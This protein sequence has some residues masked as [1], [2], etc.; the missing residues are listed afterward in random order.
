MKQR[1]NLLMLEA[2]KARRQA[3]GYLLY[4]FWVPFLCRQGPLFYVPFLLK[5]GSPSG[6]LLIGEQWCWRP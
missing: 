1:R 2:L 6:P 3:A 5:I 4:A